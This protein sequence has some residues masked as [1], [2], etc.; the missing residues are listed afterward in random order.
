MIR[1]KSMKLFVCLSFEAYS[2][3][4]APQDKVPILLCCLIMRSEVSDRLEE[5]SENRNASNSPVV[6]RG[7]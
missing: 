2:F 7:V 4:S 6:S 3:L 5:W 1:L